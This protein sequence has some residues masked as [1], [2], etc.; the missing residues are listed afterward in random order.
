MAFD[1]ATRNELQKLVGRA[2]G[3]LVDEFMSQC[4]GVYGIQ[5][6]GSALEISTLGHL[7][8]ED[9]TKAGLL[10][11]RVNH[12]AAGIAGSKKRAEAV[13]RVVRE[14]AFTVLNRLCALRM[15]EERDLVQ[16]CVRNG[17]D[18]KGFRLYD[19]AA[20]R[21]GGDTYSR[22]QLFLQLLFDELAIDLGILFDRFSLY[23]LLFPRENALTELLQ[24]INSRALSHIWAEDEAI[25]WVYQY[26]NS[27][28]ER[29]AMRK[30]ADAPRNSRE[31]AVRNQFFT[32]RYVVEFLTDNSLGRIW[33]E[34]QKGET[35]LK[36]TCRYLV[37]RPSEVFLKEEETPTKSNEDVAAL[38]E[39]ERLSL[40]TYIAHREKKDP[41]DI[42]VIDPACGSGHFLLYA[43]DLLETIYREAWQDPDPPKNEVTGLS[44]RDEYASLDDL[45]TSIPELILCW[46]LHGVDIDPRAAQIAAL[47]LWLRAQKAWQKQGLKSYRRPQVRKSNIV[48]AEP[49]PGEKELLRDFTSRLKPPLL[50][51]LV[52]VVFDRM[53]L[54]GEAGSLLRIEE[55]I[56][57]AIDTAREQWLSGPTPEQEELFPETARDK[58]NEMSFNFSGVTRDSFWVQAEE[59]ILQ[60]LDEYAE[61]IQGGKGQGRRLFAEDASQGFAFVDI[62][63]RK[64]DVVVMNPPFGYAAAKSRSYID[65]TYPAAKYDVLAAFIEMAMHRTH[66][67]GRI[68]AI[69]SR[70]V[71]YTEFFRAWRKNLL[72]NS[73]IEVFADL[74]SGVLDALVETSAY[75]IKQSTS[76]H[77]SIFLRLLSEQAKDIALLSHIACIREERECSESFHVNQK[78]F[79]PLDGQPFAYWVSQHI[80]QIMVKL[81]SLGGTGVDVKVG[82]QSGDDF[83]FFRL[84]W[85]VPHYETGRGNRWIYLAKGGEYRKF[86]DDVHLMVN[87]FQGGNEIKHFTD[88]RGKL[89]SRPQNI[90]YYFREGI[91]YPMRTRSNFSP[92]VLPADCIFNVQGNAVFLDEEHEDD[93]LM[94]L[95]GMLSSRIFEAFTRVR[96]R[97]GDTTTA[98]GAGFAYTPGVIASTPVPNLSEQYRKKLAMLV[99]QCVMLEWQI[100]RFSEPSNSYVMFAQIVPHETL[101]EFLKKV[102]RN[103]E[104]MELSILETA[105][106]IELLMEKAYEVSEDDIEEINSQMGPRVCSYPAILE[107][108]IKE[109]LKEY[110]LTSEVPSELLEGQGTQQRKISIT[111]ALTLGELSRVLRKHPST[112]HRLISENNWF[113]RDEIY[114]E[115]EKI[116]S[117]LVGSAFGRW[118]VRYA[119][120]E[121]ELPEVYRPFEPLSAVAPGM[122]PDETLVPDEYGIHIARKGIMVDD[123]NHK[124][125]IISHVREVLIKIW[126]DRADSVEQEICQVLGVRELRLYLR[127][128]T[129]FFSDHLNRYSKSRR[130]APIY[131]PL[132]TESG[133]YIIWLYY[134]KLSDQT[135][136]SCVNDFIDPKLKDIVRDI[137]RLRTGVQTD[138]RNQIAIDELVGLERELKALREELLRVTKIPYKPD[139]NDGVLITAAPLWQLF[140]HKPWHK[141][142]KKCWVE[143]EAG[144]YDWAHMAHSIWPDRVQKTCRK[145]KSIAIAHGLEELYE[146]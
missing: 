85:E 144:K 129:K 13:A 116:V 56:Q 32:P 115:V 73:V 58:Q 87:W 127:K 75:V 130:K 84:A 5:P 99:R 40:P 9:R 140:R 111:G 60:S 68:G 35:A 137:D 91:T 44:L 89:R 94:V 141:E 102:I 83:R 145:D 74:G 6:D 79:E 80:L 103:V 37:Q 134:P 34:M 78:D 109:E 71:F 97:V 33:Y 117:Y 67:H 43:F 90:G 20:T 7:S 24:Q 106:E 121:L 17:Y 12:L 113:R 28:E 107:R 29:Q 96:A 22:Y 39:K 76:Q 142:L 92:R 4:Q 46:N 66:S 54:A 2:R 57:A 114:R 38:K 47:S 82:L 51:Q 41:R 15:C 11:D 118:D 69:T 70:T 48:C 104:K 143:L 112:I 123:E 45:R 108:P 19:Q 120:G 132:S 14:Q 63:R 21:L 64:F 36:E 135:L 65:K 126:G 100:D 72:D 3:L 61:E 49:M 122:L 10:R 23:G 133:N 8:E 131:W 55:D 95:L 136:Y 53:Q 1:T 50:G 105:E 42:K 62:C 146:G 128:P 139:E 124:D 27:Q 52:E 138:R 77:D 18:S 98:G 31:L 93:D 119:S 110:Y 125:D 81:R 26:F 30:E 101:E 16:E 86:Y 25:G 88:D 59:K